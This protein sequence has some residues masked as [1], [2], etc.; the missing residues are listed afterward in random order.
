MTTAQEPVS[1]SKIKGMGG[2][3]FTFGVGFMDISKLHEFVPA[4]V[5]S[6]ND[7]HLLI[8]GTG[9]GITNRLVL[10]GSGVGILGEK[11]HTDSLEVNTG[12]GYGVFEFGYLVCDKR[13]MKIYP[14]IGIGAGGMNV[15]ISNSKTVPAD[16]VSNNPAQEIH[17]RNGGFLTDISITINFIP[18]ITYDEKENSSGGFMIGIQ[19]GYLY[20][21]PSSD[22]SYSGGSI[23]G[24]P[25]FGINMPYVKLVLGGFGWSGKE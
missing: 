24:G 18:S 14:T 20:G 19:A 12:G 16:E 10:G 5:P 1:P 17:I 21:I 4:S 8:G 9:H 13:N 23:S 25:R 3:G 11:Y 6:F 2:G 15:Q 22:W 7:K